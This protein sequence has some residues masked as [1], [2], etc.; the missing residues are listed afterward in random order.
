VE[1]L[2]D[3]DD[4]PQLASTTGLYDGEIADPDIRIA[5]GVKV[6]NL[7]DFLKLDPDDQRLHAFHEFTRSY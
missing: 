1:V 5:A 3:L 6:V 2:Q 7:T 4:L